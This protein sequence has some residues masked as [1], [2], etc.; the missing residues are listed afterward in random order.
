MPDLNTNRA[1]WDGN[2]N[3]SEAGA[4]W[5]KAWGGPDMQWWGMLYP[6]LQRLLPAARIVEIAPGYGRWT[7]YLAAHCQQL[8]GIDLSEECIDACR[9]RFRSQ[10]AL[11]FEV[12]DGKHLPSV[13]DG[14][15]DLLFSFDSLVHVESDVIISYIKEAARVL[16]PE[17][18]AFLHHSNLARYPLLEARAHNAHWRAESVSASI[19]AAVSELIGLTVLSQE[20]HVWGGDETLLSDCITV[21]AKNGSATPTHHLENFSFSEEMRQLRRLAALYAG[22]EG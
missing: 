5:S 10:S 21:L 1:Y 9:E 20:E 18:R 15:V 2:Y 12:G 17:G 13:E 16:A 22:S 8:T 7:H 4:E 19:V 14:S 3:W 6:R 11:S